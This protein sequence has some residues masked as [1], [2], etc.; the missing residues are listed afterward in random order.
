MP[1]AFIPQ[2]APLYFTAYVSCVTIVVAVI[3]NI[4]KAMNDAKTSLLFVINYLL[5]DNVGFIVYSASIKLTK[6]EISLR[7]STLVGCTTK[8]ISITARSGDRP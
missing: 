2:K 4:A 6:L 3:A 5:A 7:I 1:C 8:N